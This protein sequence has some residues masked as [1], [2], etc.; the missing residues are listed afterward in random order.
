MTTTTLIQA[1][2]REKTARATLAQVDWPGVVEL[3]DYR[4]W[5][6]T[7]EQASALSNLT[8]HVHTGTIL[9]AR[10]VLT[11]I[12]DRG[13]HSNVTLAIVTLELVGLM[14]EA[15]VLVN[16]EARCALAEARHE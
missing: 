7:A 1:M 5:H 9:A 16:A 8:E 11:H 13:G 12:G 4:G 10:A 14:A 3:L 2:R 6:C 15:L